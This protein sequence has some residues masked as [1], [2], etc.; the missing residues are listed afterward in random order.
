[1]YIY[2][3]IYIYTHIY[4]HIHVLSEALTGP[5]G[6][7]QALHNWLG[8]ASNATTRQRDVFPLP[9]LESVDVPHCSS[10]SCRCMCIL[11]LPR[12][13]NKTMQPKWRCWVALQKVAPR[14]VVQRLYGRSSSSS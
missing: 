7:L 5:R 14:P 6:P 10:V 4:I 11:W 2:I 3:Y 9:H 12:I 1:M 8:G 13:R